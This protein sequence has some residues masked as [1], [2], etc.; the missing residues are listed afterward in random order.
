M[1]FL[2]ENNKSIVSYEDLEGKVNCLM[3]AVRIVDCITY[4]YTSKD[5]K[6]LEKE[7]EQK[8][9]CREKTEKIEEKKDVSFSVNF[10]FLHSIFSF[11][12]FSSST[13]TEEKSIEQI[14]EVIE[15]E[16]QNEILEKMKN[17]MKNIEHFSS[18]KS[19][20][21][22][23]M[24]FLKICKIHKNPGIRNAIDWLDNII[25]FKELNEIVYCSIRVIDGSISGINH[26]V[27]GILNLP[28]NKLKS[29]INISTGLLEI[30]K[31]GVDFFDTYNKVENQQKEKKLKKAQLNFKQIVNKMD[32]KFDE[33]I[34]SNLE[35]FKKN[36]IIIL[37]IDQSDSVYNEET[38]LQFFYINNINNYAKCINENDKDRA[39][40][41]E[42][43]IYFYQKILP[44]FSE[45]TNEG[46]Q[47]INLKIDFFLSLQALI[48]NKCKD[49]KFWIELDK[50]KI[51][52]FIDFMEKEYEKR[53][54][55]F[56]NNRFWFK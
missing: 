42:N 50:D 7:Q 13:K 18:Y 4:C 47:E 24:E 45:L 10:D 48:I 15:K 33:L 46:E 27:Q 30:T 41:I 6:S 16:D 55:Y 5:D 22:I 23:I 52:K 38:D 39:K 49:K 2:K 40:Y 21:L 14:N 8:C 28:N 20:I 32:T 51:E 3:N 56:K 54:D 17:I 1:K 37:G 19:Y 34:N 29:I 44:K 43:M 35:E 12:Y 26:I 11:S 36:N 53:K 25:P 9:Q 31:A